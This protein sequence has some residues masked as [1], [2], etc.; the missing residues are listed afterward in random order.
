[1]ARVDYKQVTSS[2]QTLLSKN[3]R[4]FVMNPS[5]FPGGSIP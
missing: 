2:C 4:R 1:V 5:G 3:F